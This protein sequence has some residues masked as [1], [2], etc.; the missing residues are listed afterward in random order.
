MK[1]PPRACTIHAPAKINLHLEI[2]GVRPDGFHELESLFVCLDFGD[3]LR[4]EI[5]RDKGFVLQTINQKFP[6]EF[7][8]KNNLISRAVRVFCEKTGFNEGLQCFLDKK[9]P[10]G[11]GLGGGSSDAASAL[12]A[13]NRLSQ[14][15]LSLEKLSE[16]AVLLGSDVPFF[17]H[18][19]AAV[20]KGRGEII[21]PLA[22]SFFKQSSFI[23]SGPAR[24]FG[25]GGCRVILIKPPFSSDTAEAYRLLDLYREK[26]RGVKNNLLTVSKEKIDIKRI[27]NS[28]PGKWPFSN[29]FL[30]VLPQTDIYREIIKNL[31]DGGADFAGLSGSGSC[32]FGVF[33]DSKIAENHYKLQQIQQYFIQNT[34][35]LASAADPVLE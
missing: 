30:S 32:C 19:G 24:F 2:G 22:G 31:L 26:H 12:L 5:V 11:A 25:T 7:Y 21:E 34:F 33:T 28:E 10:L 20:V 23:K 3:D 17:L 27:L 9:I 8:G 14:K 15:N 4:F 6:A 13:L 1:H 18:G 35:F 16:M 29:D